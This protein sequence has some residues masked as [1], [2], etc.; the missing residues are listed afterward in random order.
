MTLTSYVNYI[1]LPNT[2][3]DVSED[4]IIAGWGTNSFEGDPSDTL[5]QARIQIMNPNICSYV[6]DVFNPRKQICAGT[7]DYSKDSC[8]GDSGGPLMDLVNNQWVLNG[9]VSYGD[10]CAKFYRPGVYA[11]VSYYLPW[12]RATISSLSGQ[13]ANQ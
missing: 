1:C 10:E 2:D 3:P 4:V 6:Y 11:R 8:Q 9:V 13:R 7:N 12:I 5:Q